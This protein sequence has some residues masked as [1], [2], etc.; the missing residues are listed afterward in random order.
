MARYICKSAHYCRRK[1]THAL[2]IT[3]MISAA[4]EARR[5]NRSLILFIA[6]HYIVSVVNCRRQISW[7]IDSNVSDLGRGFRRRAGGFL[8]CVFRVNLRIMRRGL[9]HIGNHRR[10]KQYEHDCSCKQRRLARYL[11]VAAARPLQFL[12]DGN[13]LEST[14][15]LKYRQE[16]LLILYFC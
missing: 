5:F 15:K 16:E 9:N 6:L 4:T 11:K 3:G 10:D 13:R 7:R 2:I 1:T 12:V 8:P 14:I